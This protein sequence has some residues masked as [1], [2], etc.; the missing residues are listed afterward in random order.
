MPRSMGLSGDTRMSSRE[1]RLEKTFMGLSLLRAKEN[2][3]RGGFW[4]GSGCPRI[5]RQNS[6]KKSWKLN[7]LARAR[8]GFAKGICAMPNPIATIPRNTTREPTG[9]LAQK[10][11]S[12][13]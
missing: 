2:P 10:P 11:E 1:A 7:L 5:N 13:V 6:I 3:P 8:F 9:V 12:A 4:F